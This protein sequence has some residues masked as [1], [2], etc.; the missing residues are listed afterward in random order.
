MFS[1]E[2]PTW[3]FQNIKSYAEQ[4]RRWVME[5]MFAWELTVLE[6]VT[7]EEFERVL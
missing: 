6:E 7:L 5:N 4:I 2:I 3:L 1:K